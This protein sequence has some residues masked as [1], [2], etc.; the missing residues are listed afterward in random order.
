MI[1]GLFSFFLPCLDL[2]LAEIKM[3]CFKKLRRN[4]LEREQAVKKILSNYCSH[5]FI[6]YLSLTFLPSSK[7]NMEQ[8]A[9][10]KSI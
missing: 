9:H 1:D 6:F 10:K 2:S 5:V 7:Y 4:G 8:N 3:P